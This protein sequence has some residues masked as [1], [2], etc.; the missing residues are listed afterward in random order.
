MKKTLLAATLLAATS[1]FAGVTGFT[2]YDYDNAN[3]GQGAARYQQEVHVG[4]ALGTKLG[5]FDGAVV[6][7]RATAGAADDQGGFELGYSNGLKLGAVS[8]TGRAAYGRLNQVSGGNFE[9]YSLGAEASLPITSTVTG[10]AGYRFRDATGGGNI[11]NRFTVGADF[12]LTKAIAL[13]AGYAF[14]KQDGLNFNG[15]TTAVAV[16]F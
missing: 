14:T 4:A 5:T 16:K 6:G 9:Y 11:Q 7:R 12:A 2:S 15:L 3:D 10:F 13:R 8:V 1:A